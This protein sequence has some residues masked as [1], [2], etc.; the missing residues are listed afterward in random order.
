MTGTNLFLRSY[1][2][3]PSLDMHGNPS[4]GITGTLLTLRKIVGLCSP[5]KIVFAWDGAG[6]SKRRRAI[7]ENY[8][9]G[10]RPVKLN[11]NFEFEVED[12]EKNKINQRIRLGEYLNDLPIHQV[13]VEGIE[14]DDAIAYLC[15]YYAKERKVIASSDKD[16]IQLLNENTIMYNIQKKAYVTSP[17]AYREH[18][19]HPRNY[20]LARAL[21]GDKSDNIKGIKGI[22]FKTLFK[23]F[24]FFLNKEKIE[25]EQF[26]KT[27][28]DAGEKYEK[29]IENK[30][31]ILDNLKVM[32][33]DNSFISFE[34]EQKI[35]DV[36]KEKV[37][38]NSTSFRVKVMEDALFDVSENFFHPFKVI[39]LKENQNDAR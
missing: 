35:L 9:Q 25:L 29:F 32:R 27:C 24:P 34:S 4:G 20:A 13:I 5:D 12:E 8:K 37:S 15:K 2:A 11:R 19:I 7:I 16:F 31:V 18:K 3:V 30:N 10:R 6:G 33:L 1:A 23:L 22:G 21:V 14:A 28:E 38:L 39:Q 26:F 36:I 17:D